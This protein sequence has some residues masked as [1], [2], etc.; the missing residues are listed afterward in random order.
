MALTQ[1]NPALFA[2]ATNTT[3]VI[4]SNGTT[5]ITVDSS[6]NVGIGTSSPTFAAGGGLNVVNGSFA[7]MRA[8]SGSTTGIDFAQSSDGNGYVYNRDNAQVIFGTNNTQ[9]MSINAGAPIICLSG[10]NT[11]ATGTGIAFP[12]TQSASTDA[13]TLDDYEEGT[14]TPVLSASG[15]AP[16]VAYNYRSG[17]YRKIGSM[18]YVQFA[19]NLASISG[20]SG[21]MRIDGLPFT[22]I[23]RG[24]YQEPTNALNGGNWVTAAYAGQTYCFVGDSST[25]IYGRYQNN[26]DT[27][28]NINQFQGGSP[29]TYFGAIMVYC[30]A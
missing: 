10:G 15:S 21:E 16:T 1:I 4:Q 5:A 8:R 17:V 3:A 13:N 27:S 30:A 29:G 11:S 14:W 26:G 24:P 12:A 18:V 28:I 23:S 6:Q 9:R 19:F 7:T 25:S 22:S 2:G 20:G